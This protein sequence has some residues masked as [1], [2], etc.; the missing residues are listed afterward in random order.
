MFYEGKL[1]N[2]LSQSIYSGYVKTEFWFSKQDN[3]LTYYVNDLPFQNL[4]M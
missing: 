1:I 3:R 4:A 2:P